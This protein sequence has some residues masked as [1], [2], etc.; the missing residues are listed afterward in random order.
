MSEK[1]PTT[2]CPA[3]K[4]PKHNKKNS[5]KTSEFFSRY[6]PVE[7]KGRGQ[8]TLAPLQKFPFLYIYNSL[9]ILALSAQ[10]IG[11]WSL[12]KVLDLNYKQI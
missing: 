7:E 1:H 11:S 10:E 6:Q 8:G 2:S 12:H 4:Q 9:D 5:R 3:A